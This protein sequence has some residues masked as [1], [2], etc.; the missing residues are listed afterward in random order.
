VEVVNG[1][2]EKNW[3]G[4]GYLLVLAYRGQGKLL[5]LSMSTQVVAGDRQ[6]EREMP[7]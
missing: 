3:G 2:K 5:S 7:T 1:E 6:R 4:Q